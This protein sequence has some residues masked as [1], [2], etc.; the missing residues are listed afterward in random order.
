MLAESRGTVIPVGQYSI[1]RRH[2]RYLLSV[3]VTVHRFTPWRPVVVHGLSLDISEGGAS[4]VL[5]GAPAV[6]EAVLVSLQL[7]NA[8]L[9]SLAIVRHSSATRS[10]FEFFTP[11]RELR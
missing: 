6:G 9:Q 2:P 11:A 8:P 1:P 7:P 4:A 3:P 5:C 10:G